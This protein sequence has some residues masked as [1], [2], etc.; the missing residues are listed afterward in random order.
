MNDHFPQSG[1][2]IKFCLNVIFIQME[3]TMR[4][5]SVDTLP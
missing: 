5:K 3:A 2:V 1:K 4:D